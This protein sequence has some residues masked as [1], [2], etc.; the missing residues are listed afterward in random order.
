MNIIYYI[1]NLAVE[2]PELVRVTLTNFGKIVNILS[3]EFDQKVLIL[4]HPKI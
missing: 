1:S 2:R 4:I 3:L